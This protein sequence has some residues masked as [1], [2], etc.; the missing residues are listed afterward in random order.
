MFAGSG[1]AHGTDS[2]P[3]GWAWTGEDGPELVRFR[4]GETVVPHDESMRMAGGGT[5][6]RNYYIQG[7]VDDRSL[8]QIE[9]AEARGSSRGGRR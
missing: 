3:P 9:R 5:V 8:T 2:A 1:F 6:V 7:R 4:G